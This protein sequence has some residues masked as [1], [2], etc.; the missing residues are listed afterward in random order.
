MLTRPRPEYSV[1]DFDIYRYHKGSN[2]TVGNFYPSDYTR[3]FYEGMKQ[4]GQEEIVSLVRCAWAGSQKYGALVW[5]GDIAS[6]WGSLRN[7]LCAGLSM[8]I[9]GFA[10][11][12]TDIGGF[13]GGVPESPQ[14]RELLVRW[15]QWGMVPR[16]T[17][18]LRPT[19]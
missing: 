9:A 14:F 4:S 19:D 13:H 7:Q 15:F 2:L 16:E 18:I 5:S 11:F 12:T 6:S 3:G 17:L 1:Y 10:W 8:A